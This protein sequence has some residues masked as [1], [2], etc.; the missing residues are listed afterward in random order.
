MS[1]G[2]TIKYP[3]EKEKKRQIISN[4]FREDIRRRINISNLSYFR[5]MIDI[6]I[7]PI[8]DL[9]AQ[10]TLT[11]QIFRRLLEVEETWHIKYIDS[12]YGYDFK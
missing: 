11:L 9:N 7:S 6:L 8:I 5:E 3:R 1:F 12:H 2:D 4:H 10:I